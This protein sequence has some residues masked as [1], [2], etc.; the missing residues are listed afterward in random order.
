[1]ERVVRSCRQ[2]EEEGLSLNTSFV[3]LSPSVWISFTKD[4]VME[5]EVDV[6][7]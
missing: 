7:R 4:V 6:G 2:V 3:M 1:M 5:R